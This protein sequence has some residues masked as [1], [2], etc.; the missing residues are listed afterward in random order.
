PQGDLVLDLAK[1]VDRFQARWDLSTGVCKLVRLSGE[2]AAEQTLS[3]AATDLHKP[4][5]YH[6]QLAN[7]D[8]RLTVFV[9]SALPFGDGIAYSPP[10]QRGPTQQD[11]EP[12][13]IGC[14]G[15]GIAVNHLKVWR[16]TY[17][18]VAASEADAG[19]G[20]SWDFKSSVWHDPN[21]WE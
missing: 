5:T 12:V 1:G 8:E 19:F 16:D 21:R 11:L 15:A 9:D 2:A 14:R 4:G 17:Y 13:R 18:T 6:V 10:K 20:E 7:V 3:T